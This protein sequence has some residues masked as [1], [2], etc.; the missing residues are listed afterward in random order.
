MTTATDLMIQEHRKGVAASHVE[1]IEVEATNHLDA[2][3]YIR[4]NN[5][6]CLTDYGYYGN[7]NNDVYVG[8][9]RIY[10]N[11]HLGN[12][13]TEPGVAHTYG[14]SY[15]LVLRNGAMGA[16]L[17]KAMTNRKTLE[18]ILG[19]T[20]LNQLEQQNINQIKNQAKL[21]INMLENNN[22]DN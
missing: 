17:K 20:S 12:E 19:T 21:L 15:K 1:S 3:T 7:E 22:A 2:T 6:P 4:F 10:T 16:H 11:V 14:I 18:N 13:Y 9:L 8:S 5:F